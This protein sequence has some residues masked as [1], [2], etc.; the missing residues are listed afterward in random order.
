MLRLHVTFHP[1]KSLQAML[2]PFT[3]CAS[4]QD[5]FLCPRHSYRL[6]QTSRSTQPFRIARFP[7]NKMISS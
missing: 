3:L 6:S 7:A 4:A 5:G 2:E 1:V